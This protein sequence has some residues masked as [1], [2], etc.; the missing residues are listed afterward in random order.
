MRIWLARTEP[1]AT[2]QAASLAANGFG[3]LKAPVLGIEALQ[4][5]PP[6]GPFDVVVFV[7]EHAVSCAAANGWPCGP[8]IP[9]GT[10]AARALQA[11]GVEP[12]WPAQ[13]NAQGVIDVL[14]PSPPGRVLV[15]KGQGGRTTLQDWLRARERTV[16]E[17]DV[18]RRVP[19]DP[20]IQGE[21]VDAIV[22]ASGDGL[23]VVEQLWFA[24]P[25]DARVP[26]LVPSER[27]AELAKAMRFERVLVTAGAGA[28]AVVAGLLKLR[29]GSGNG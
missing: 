19:L 3:V 10:A 6:E 11:R 18:Y 4:T 13:A 25:R 28:S 1:G 14:A 12:S 22:A 24:E 27:V 16:V 2:R 8:A 7:S 9:I 21:R 26:L 29:E 23:R 17:W 5:A 20:G 15:V